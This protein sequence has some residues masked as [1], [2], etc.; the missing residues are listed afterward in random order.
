MKKFGYAFKLA[1]VPEKQDTKAERDVSN[2]KAL[3]ASLA[4][5]IGNGNIAGVATAVTLGGS[6]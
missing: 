2:S 6:G 4:G 3:M 1:F 5:M